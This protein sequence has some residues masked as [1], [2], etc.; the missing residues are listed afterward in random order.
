MTENIKP[1]LI[2]DEMKESYIDYAMSVIIGRALPDVRD[3]LKPVH[4]RVLFTMQ[5]LAL[6][7]NKPF[8]KCARIVGDCLGRFHPHGDTSVYFALVRMAQEFSLRYPLVNGQGNFGSIDGDSAAAMRYTEAKMEKIAEEML[9]DIDKETVE[10]IPNFDGSMKEPTV[11][12]SRIP[13]LLINGS[14]GIAVGM[15]T[16]IPPHNII[17]IVDATLLLLDDPETS[18]LNLC[19]VVK[20]P[21]FP[22]GGIICGTAGIRTAY[23]NGRGKVKVRAKAE[24]EETPK[25]NRIIVTE[26]PYMVNKSSLIENIAYQVNEKLIEGISDI[27]DESNREGMRIVIELKRDISPDVVLNQLYKRTAMQ[28]TFG[29]NMLALHNNQPKVMGL[30]DLI[31]Y[32]I[33]HRKDVIIKRS[34]YELRK[35]EEKAHL[36]EGL[37]IALQNIEEVVQLIKKSASAQDAKSI[38]MQSYELTEVQSQAI[39]DMKLQKLTSLEQDKLIQEIKDLLKL[40]EDLKDILASEQRIIDII[41]ED[42]IEIKQ[43]YGDDRKTEITEVQ[44]EIEDVDLIP[45]E[46]VVITATYSGYIKK[47]PLDEYKHQKRGGYG[48]KGAQTKEEDVVEHLI[49]AST[50]ST[51]LCF[52][53]KGKI[54][55]L[56]GFQIP[57]ASKYSKGKAII[58]LLRLDKD[59]KIN[60][61]IPLKEFHDKHYLIMVT[62]KGLIK[63]TDLD[64]YSNPRKGG[65][66]AIKLMPKDELVQVRLTPGQLKFIV[67]SKKGQAVRFDEQ[68]VRAMGR[69]ATGVRAIKLNKD[70]EVIGLE[71]A[72]E[73]ATLLSV[74]ENGYGKRS[75]VP[76]YRLT[77]RGG[78]GVINIKTSA[79]NG[80]VIGIKTVMDHDEII[81]IT[82]QGIVIRMSVS[83]V[84]VIGRNTLGVR[85]MKLRENDKVKTV[86]RIIPNE[87]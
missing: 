1:K 85:I 51:I 12:P 40:I 32:F 41:K 35:A 72:V 9:V 47:L 75:F 8:K 31:T 16:N 83:D 56:K 52:S 71:V 45:E 86:A 38:L 61:M 2:E 10:F 5:E 30:K 55:W 20:G 34:Q 48:V 39:L 68:D 28:T 46:D 59:E 36:L 44:D 87:N 43:K 54:Y 7:H 29:M 77:K 69:N 6:Q 13:N 78:K 64:C 23:K 3:G 14:T 73:T 65:I 67:G 76:D 57:T 19:E 84:S 82:E 70:D 49:T 62:K 11:L 63:K 74:T 60:T 37:K 80:N 4:R 50:H 15:A 25:K 33:E 17:E 58:N 42:L 79:R 24:I 66:I 22:T 53:N 81:L 26:I 27:R 21:D 18:T